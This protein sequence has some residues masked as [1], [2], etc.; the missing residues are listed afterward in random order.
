MTISV[1]ITWILFL[2]LFPIAFFWLRRA[3]RILVKRDFSEVALKGGLSPS[4]PEKF[5]PYAA[6]INLVAGGVVVA[7]IL[8][9]VIGGVAYDIWSAIAGSTIWM[10][11]FA[12]FI[13][14]RHAHPMWG[15][16]KVQPVPKD[17]S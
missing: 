16:K 3:W 9:I 1:A 6:A 13:L 14:S 2:G 15:K 17:R 4:D 8:M 7:V 12:D 5:A 11:F 10:K